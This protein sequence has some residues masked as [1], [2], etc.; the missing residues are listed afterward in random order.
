MYRINALNTNLVTINPVDVL[1]Q[2]NSCAFVEACDLC[3]RLSQQLGQRHPH[4]LL[5][6]RQPLVDLG[7]LCDGDWCLV[8]DLLALA[9][10]DSQH[11]S[12]VLVEQDAGNSSKHLFEVLLQFGHI[13][14]VADD[15]KQVLVSHKVEPGNKKSVMDRLRIVNG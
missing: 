15:F 1:T 7:V 5:H 12:V 13:L 10:G 3:D 9:G 6:Q 11:H 2:V 8:K 4:L 14:A